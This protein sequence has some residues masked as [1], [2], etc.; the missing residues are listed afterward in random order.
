MRTGHDKNGFVTLVGAGPGDAD[1][2]TVRGLRALEQADIV[3]Y[4]S[5]VSSDLLDDLQAQTIHVGKRC[6]QHAM[7]QEETTDLMVRLARDG[8]RVVRLKGGDPVVLGRGGE[9]AL[10]LAREGIPF[11][12]VPGVSSAIAAPELAGIPVTFRGTAD[13]FTVLTAHRRKD[14]TGF[15]IPPYYAGTT[16]VL[17]MGVA[18]IEIWQRQMLGLGYPETVPVA[19]IVS[20]A[21]ADQHVVRT[22]LRDAL[23]DA[24]AC[25]VTSPAVAVVGEVVSLQ[26]ELAR[27]LA[28]RDTAG[29]PVP[30]S[31]ASTGATA[32]EPGP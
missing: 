26:A 6:G 11:E 16:L 1:L 10:R 27:T 31:R 32:G 4:D 2:I 13:S 22:T 30:I 28:G 18:T 5:L 3:L 17:L 23:R 29:E 21:S 20:A 19:F 15:S 25:N 9:E 8:K 24:Q 12:F 7:R 14:E